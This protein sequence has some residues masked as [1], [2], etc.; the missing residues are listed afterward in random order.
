MDHSEPAFTRRLLAMLTTAPDA[1]GRLL[2]SV[3]VLVLGATALRSAWQGWLAMFPFVVMGVGGLVLMGFLRRLGAAFFVSVL[4]ALAAPLLMMIGVGR[5]IGMGVVESI[6]RPLPMLLT[7]TF[8]APVTLTLLLPGLVVMWAAGA[9]LGIGLQRK[10]F[11]A[12]PLVSGAGLLVVADLLTAGGSDMFGL[13]S[14]ALVAVVLVHWAMWGRRRG[15]P[16]P[17]LGAAALLGAI[18]LAIGFVPLGTPYQPRQAVRPEVKP[19]EEPNPLQWLSQWAADPDAEIMRRHGDTFALHLAVLPEYDGRGFY[20][21]SQYV[22]MGSAVRPSLPGGRYQVDQT[23]TVTWQP[24]SRWLPAPGMPQ[25]VSVPDAQHDPETGSLLIPRFPSGVFSYT[26]TGT[27]DVPR[28]HEIAAANVGPQ[29]RYTELPELPES[30]TTYAKDVTAGAST[31]LEQAQ[32]L[33]VALKKDR[34]YSPRSTSGTSIGRLDQFLFATPDKGGRMG[35]SEQFAASFTLLARS[36]GMPT[37]LVVGFGRGTPLDEATGTYSVKGRD[38]LAWPEI[39]FEGFGWVP[40]NPTPQV[41]EVS[42]PRQE[43]PRTLPSTKPSPSPTPSPSPQPRPDDNDDDPDD[44]PWWLIVPAGLLTLLVGGLAVARAA[45]TGRQRRAGALGAWEH[46]R[47][48]LRL[49]GRRTRP[50]EPAPL[51]A[52]ESGITSAMKVAEA[53]ERESF[54]PAGGAP[55][56]DVWDDAVLTSRELR[57]GASWWRR[58]VWLLSPVVF[59]RR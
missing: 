36:L 22:P 2:V 34:Y 20:S 11:W 45:R 55:A 30:F 4:V 10:D 42:A 35:T 19:S 37:R 25:K 17:G 7:G 38:A 14:L 6:T 28:M 33:E 53:A 12:E 5:S 47:D 43:A 18:A 48:A 24:M 16:V 21:T 56:P 44:I 1:A 39:Y 31:Y 3:A 40:F 23:V 41:E 58:L 52:G 26:V 27:I 50:S 54:G 32:R 51:T 29:G 13:I 9:L 57:R 15:E 59:W 46:V 8:P 49:G